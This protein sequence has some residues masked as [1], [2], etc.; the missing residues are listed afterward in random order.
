MRTLVD[1]L[2]DDGGYV[3][4]FTGPDGFSYQLSAYLARRIPDLFEQ[5]SGYASIG[6]VREAARHQLS[7][8]S[9]PKRRRQSRR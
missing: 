6:D 9:P 8:L 2:H 5:M 1:L 7:S 3:R 4:I